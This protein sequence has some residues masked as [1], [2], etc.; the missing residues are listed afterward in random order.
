MM[1]REAKGDYTSKAHDDD[2]A[3]N[4]DCNAHDVRDVCDDT[5]DSDV[6][7]THDR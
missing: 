2:N 4:G 5:D 3:V 7:Y 6:Y 1:P